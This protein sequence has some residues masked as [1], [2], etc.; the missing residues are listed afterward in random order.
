MEPVLL[1]VEDSHFDIEL[2]QHAFRKA[3]LIQPLQ[4]VRDGVDAMSYLLGVGEFS[5]RHKHP[6][7]H[8][9]LMD[10]NMPRFNGLEFLTWLRNQPEFQHLMVVV[11]SG[12]IRQKDIDLAYQ[13]GAKSYLVK[14]TRADELQS[15]VNAFY[16]YWIGQNHFP[17]AEPGPE[18]QVRV[19]V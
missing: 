1:L 14:P 8:I 3:G 16:N 12:T 7:P 9:L 2:L 10:L 17:L 11:L 18:R 4:V 6:L 13:M 5:D 19:L 15:L